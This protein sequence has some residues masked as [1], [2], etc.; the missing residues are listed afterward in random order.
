[1]RRIL[2]LL[3]FLWFLS[4]CRALESLP[5]QPALSPGD[6]LSNQP[7]TIVNLAGH[8][9]VLVQPSSTALVY[10]LGLLASL[11]GL[12]ALLRP[13]DQHTRRWWG[14][15]LLLWGLGA[16][17]AG[18]SYQAFSYEIKCAGRELCLWTSGWEIAYLLLSGASINAIMVAVA[19]A[20]SQG[21]RRRA[22]QAYAG[23][24]FGLYTLLLLVGSLLPVRFLI[25]FEML[26]LFATPTVLV[27][28]WLNGRGYQ[29]R[30]SSLEL[31]LLST[32]LGLA[33]VMASYFAYWLLEI[34]PYVWERGL[35][36]SE[37]DVLHLGLIAWMLYIAFAVLPRSCDLKSS[38]T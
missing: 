14:L 29:Q 1:M 11:I 4:G 2:L 5:H 9:L 22:L 13:R 10:L 27:L 3:P 25:S 36:F 37:N 23:L 6:W 15:A 7:W 30:Q 33:L 24:N 38:L 18:T 28:L 26:L 31:A 17:A 19:Y 35:W 34:G 12:L 8:E 20:S 16:L 21:R 32:W